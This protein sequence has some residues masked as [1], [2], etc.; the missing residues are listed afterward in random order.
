M[1]LIFPGFNP[2]CKEAGEKL[3]SGFVKM[4]RVNVPTPLPTHTFKGVKQ[5]RE[6]KKGD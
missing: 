4:S 1:L 5:N 2:S 6:G 3:T